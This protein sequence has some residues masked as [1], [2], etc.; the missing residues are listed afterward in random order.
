MSTAQPTPSPTPHP[1]TNVT[2]PA[3]SARPSPTGGRATGSP[4]HERESSPE[5]S[6][7]TTAPVGT[8]TPGPSVATEP[9]SLGL[10]VTAVVVLVATSWIGWHLIRRWRM[11]ADRAA[12]GVGA[13]APPPAPTSDLVALITELG[14]A[15]NAA[16]EPVGLL[17]RR[18]RAVA[19]AYG[20]DRA[21]LMVLPNALLVQLPGQE[22]G[23]VGMTTRVN[24]PLRLDQVTDLYRLSDRIERAEIDVASARAELGRIWQTPHRFSSVVQALGHGVLSAGLVLILAPSPTDVAAGFVLGASVGALKLWRPGHPSLESLFPVVG[25]FGVAVVGLFA[26]SLGLP[27]DPVSVLI[28]PLVTFIPG[29]ALTTATIE[30][31]DGQMVAGAA[32]LVQGALQLV[33][34]AF[35]IVSGAALV[36]RSTGPLP[37]P[38]SIG[39]LGAAAPYVG[40]LCFAVGM[41]IYR[42]GAPRTFGW[43]LIVLYVAYSAQVLG[44][45]TLGGY[46]SGFVGAA[47]MTPVAML[48][49]AQPG[50]PPL[51]A[52]FLPA[53]WLLVP[54]SIGLIGVAEVLARQSTGQAT[55][56]T[57]GVSIVAIALGVI[58]GLGIA[59]AIE[60]RAE[61]RR[62][63]G[64]SAGSP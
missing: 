35:G 39:M 49:A 38:S 27:V 57:A 50:G 9:V 53:F 1:S 31:S 7:T 5:P 56:L 2:S 34:L 62:V 41:Y 37:G 63:P 19:T 54:G 59:S 42:S 16:G 4:A 23:V 40:V 36:E 32:R 20:A 11:T 51:M 43:T 10:V 29:A 45:A 15:L 33:L 24:E 3:D 22:R 47:V 14:A 8:P 17:S 26:V 48:V 64:D 46:V 28:A 18:L 25:A 52:T 6:A 44:A 30:L 61:V 60:R 21:E 58:T 12:T 55:L 13:S